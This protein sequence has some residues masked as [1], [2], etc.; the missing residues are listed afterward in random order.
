MSHSDLNRTG[1]KLSMSRMIDWH[2]RRWLSEYMGEVA[3]LDLG[4]TQKNQENQ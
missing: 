1:I 3:A 2:G 4:A